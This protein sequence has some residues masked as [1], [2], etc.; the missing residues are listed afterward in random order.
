MIEEEA[1]K[2]RS[3]ENREE[4]NIAVNGLTENVKEERS[5]K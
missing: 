2:I 4:T 5:I 1:Q 3:K